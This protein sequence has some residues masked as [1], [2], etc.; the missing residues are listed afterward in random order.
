MSGEA[1]GPIYRKSYAFAVRIVRLNQYL[2]REKKEFVLNRQIL[3]SGTAIGALVSESRYAQSRADFIN[4]LKIAIKEANETRYW[5]S[6]LKDTDYISEQ[7]YESLKNDNLELIRLLTS[8]IN[9][10]Q[11]NGSDSK[12]RTQNS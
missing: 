7:S 1:E 10:T 3:R 12:N 5:L 2:E 8:I 9:T 6:L 11:Q 4:K